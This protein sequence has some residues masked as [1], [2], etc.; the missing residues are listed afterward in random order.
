[1][2]KNARIG[3]HSFYEPD[4]NAARLILIYPLI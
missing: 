1:M 2:N 4:Y 3:L